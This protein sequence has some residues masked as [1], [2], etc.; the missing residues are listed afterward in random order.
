MGS[1]SEKIEFNGR[2]IR[3]PGYYIEKSMKNSDGKF[4]VETQTRV[5]TVKQ[6]RV[7]IG[8]RD[9]YDFLKEKGIE[10]PH[11]EQVKFYLEDTDIKTR[12]KRTDL[13]IC[14]LISVW[15]EEKTVKN[16]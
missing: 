16:D 5:E 10:L 4:V 3:V 15:W 11:W 9:I 8:I 13:N 1:V 14:D 6:S 2:S 12:G 7:T